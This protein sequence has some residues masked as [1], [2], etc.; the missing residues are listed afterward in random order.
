MEI[1]Q[2]NKE[3]PWWKHALQPVAPTA[4]QRGGHAGRSIGQ[5]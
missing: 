1:L 2:K 3:D 5:K 4:E